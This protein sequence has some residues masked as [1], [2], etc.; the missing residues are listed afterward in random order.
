ME[1]EELDELLEKLV[2]RFGVLRPDNGIS[3]RELIDLI[4]DANID[5]IGFYTSILKEMDII[6]EKELKDENIPGPKTVYTL[7]PEALSMYFRR[8]EAKNQRR[9]TWAI[10]F[11]GLVQVGMVLTRALLP[12]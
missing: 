9:L 7:K 5:N 10:I 3:E 12:I 4:D 1:L 2:K 8:Q 11:L 6:Y